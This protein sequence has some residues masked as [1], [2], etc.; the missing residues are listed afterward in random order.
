[1][2]REL[3][4]IDADASVALAAR[5]MRHHEVGCL[6]VLEQGRPVGLV[7][8]RDLV[9]RGLAEN[10][11]LSQ[12][13]VAEVMSTGPLTISPERSVEEACRLMTDTGIRRLLVVADESRLIGLISWHDLAA[14]SARRP[15]ARQVG[16]YRRIVDSHGHPHRTELFRLYVSPGVPPNEVVPFAIARF[17][18]VNGRTP[19]RLVADDYE[20]AAP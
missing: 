8:D 4:T 7:T 13:R 6:P 2:R 20:V 11:D 10:A 12:W 14:F 9:V 3:V 15:Q 5:R 16:F 17:E 18:Q 19:W 1:M